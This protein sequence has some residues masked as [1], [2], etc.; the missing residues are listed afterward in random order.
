MSQYAGVPWEA[1]HSF[2]PWSPVWQ[3]LPE[4][5]HYSQT[6]VSWGGFDQC[7]SR[8]HSHN[9]AWPRALVEG[10]SL[11]RHGQFEEPELVPLV[12]LAVG[13]LVRVVCSN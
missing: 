11:D 8:T 10:P 6:A 3:R 7:L 5:S 13:T 1:S 12:E 9:L 2:S 4:S